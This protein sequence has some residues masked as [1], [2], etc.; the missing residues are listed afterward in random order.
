MSGKYFRAVGYQLDE[1]TGTIDYDAMERKALECKPK[2]IVGGASAYSREWDYKRMREIADKVGGP[3]D[4]GHGP[5][6]RT[7]RRRAAGQPREIRP[8]RHLDDPQDPCADPA[9]ALS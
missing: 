9:A 7:D 5:H 6:G 2:L 8:Y 3:A 1:K 4:G